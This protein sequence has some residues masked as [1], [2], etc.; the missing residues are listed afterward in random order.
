MKIE[1]VS[2]W[3]ELFASIAVVVTLVILVLEV[4]ATNVSLKRQ[5]AMDRAAAFSEPFLDEPMLGDIL[6]KIKAVD[7]PDPIPAQLA[8]RYDL[9]PGE[10]IAWERHLWVVWS[11]L[12]ADFMLRGDEPET[13]GMVAIL[14]S[15]PD[16]QIYLQSLAFSRYQKAFVDYVNEIDALTDEDFD[17]LRQSRIG[18]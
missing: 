3:A 16:N 6:G 12:E 10:A 7:G 5:A 17:A 8:E 18:G 1:K 15:T 2:A 13:R 11:S 9:T 14:K 4:R